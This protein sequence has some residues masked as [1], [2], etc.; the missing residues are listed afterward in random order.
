MSAADREDRL[1]ALFSGSGLARL[2]ERL[3]RRLA[4]GVPLA[5]PVVLP[6]PTPEEREAVCRLRGK[7]SRGG[8]SVSI[9]L[10]DLDAALR[11]AGLAE[12]LHAA[13]TVLFGPLDRLSAE[14]ASRELE[15]TTIFEDVI[16]LD[17]R[18]AEVATWT[19][20]LRRTG[21]LRRLADGNASVAREL[22]GR[23][24]ELL[25]WL[26]LRGVALAEVAARLVG[27]SHALD[28]GAPLGTLAL[29]LLRARFDPGEADG[30][31]GDAA[32]R[33]RSLWAKAGIMV[34]ELSA[35]ALVLNLRATG[36]GVL[37]RALALHADAGE[38]YR[39]PTRLLVR[40]PPVFT[41]EATG[42]VVY[43]TENPSVVAAAAERLGRASA[44]L[45]AT[46]GQEKTA[47][48]LLLDALAAAGVELRYHGDFDWPGLRIGSLV[49]RRHG[50]RPWRFGAAEYLAAEKL[51]PLAGTPTSAFWD[52]ALATAMAGRGGAVHE[53]AVLDDLLTDLD[54]RRT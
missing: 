31:D 29:R 37:A 11:E 18:T 41:R 44:P 26:P 27:D 12:S 7:T 3:R 39:V 19:A 15:W 17:R 42:E 53:E 6:D 28:A 47:V 16:P 8:A 38:T 32:E 14:A 4:Q 35:P 5:G 49:M 22:L 10:T 23:S 25:A 24:M 33:R 51:G 13:A 9:S 45:I 2:R 43:V 46:E 52:E 30:D 36:D 1:L 20:E 48:R 50:A 54:T 40:E 21:L 34:D